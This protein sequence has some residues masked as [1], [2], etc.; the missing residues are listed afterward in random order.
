MF[1]IDSESDLKTMAKSKDIRIEAFIG[2]ENQ[3]KS[4]VAVG[5]VVE[6]IIK[7]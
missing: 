7:Q 3:N 4:L 6:E 1:E 5:H 2:N